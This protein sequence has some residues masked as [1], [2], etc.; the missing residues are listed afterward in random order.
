MSIS[1]PTQLATVRELKNG[2]QILSPLDLGRQEQ[3]TWIG[4][5][6]E[7]R[8]AMLV[9]YREKNSTTSKVSR[10]I[11]PVEYLSSTLDDDQWYDSLHDQSTASLLTGNPVNL[12]DIGGFTLI[13]GKL[14]TDPVSGELVPLNIMSNRGE[15]GKIHVAGDAEGIPHAEVARQKYFSVSNSLYYEPWPKIQLGV[16][17]LAELVA[18]SVA[19]AYSQE[20]LADS[21]FDILSTDTYD[22]IVR[23]KKGQFADQK[24]AELRNSIYIPPLDNACVADCSSATA[25]ESKYYG[26]RTQ[27]VI[28]LHK[29]G[30]LHYYERDLYEGNTNVQHVTKQHFVFDLNSA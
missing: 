22:P 30:H 12:G 7:G 8:I 10:G 13:Y 19:N 27:T 11:L 4:I 28:M 9:N 15:H 6:S 16:S 26:T 21:C 18:E 2:A 20:K 23:E 24:L 29:S 5:T 1:R 17:K 3:G 14:Q 25:P